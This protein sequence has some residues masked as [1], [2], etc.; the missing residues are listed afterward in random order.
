MAPVGQEGTGGIGGG[1]GGTL[2]I[3]LAP[4]TFHYNYG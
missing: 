1:G 3:N 4:N 2:Q